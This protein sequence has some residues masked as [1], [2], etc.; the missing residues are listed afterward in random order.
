LKPLAVVFPEEEDNINAFNA[1][2]QSERK[3]V[4][5]ER[6]QIPLKILQQQSDRLLAE[7]F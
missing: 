5:Q 1:N 2:I 4:K 6:A 3:I 7:T